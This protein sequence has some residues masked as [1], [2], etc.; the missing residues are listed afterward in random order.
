MKI[1]VACPDFLWVAS[2]NRSAD[3]GDPHPQ[4]V[5]SR[6]LQSGG[7]GADGLGLE[8]GADGVDLAEVLR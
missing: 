1:R 4:L 3:L 2:A 6:R 8:R 5:D 7:D